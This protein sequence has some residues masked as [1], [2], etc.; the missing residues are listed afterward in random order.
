MTCAGHTQQCS[1]D[2]QESKNINEHRDALPQ[3]A[4][5]IEL[6]AAMVYDMSVPKDVDLVRPAVCPVAGKIQYKKGNNIGKPCSFDGIDGDVVHQP[7]I[8]QNGDAESEYIFRYIG[9]A[10]S[11]AGDHVHVSHRILAFVP[12]VPLLRQHQHQE[13]GH[14][15]EQ[16]FTVCFHNL[17][18][19]CDIPPWGR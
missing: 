4:G 7:F 2:K 12:T 3:C 8:R 1:G 19:L 11:K 13:D 9:D 16:N 17:Y 14:G 5:E 6:F 10:R 15:N 18:A